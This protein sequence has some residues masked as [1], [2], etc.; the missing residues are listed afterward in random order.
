MKQGIED[1]VA[2]LKKKSVPMKDDARDRSND[3]PDYLDSSAE[4]TGLEPAA[5]CGVPQFQ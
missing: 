2:N 4:D 3:Y 5:P 1:F